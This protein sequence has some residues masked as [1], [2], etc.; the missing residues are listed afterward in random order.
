MIVVAVFASVGTYL[1][2]KGVSGLV[3]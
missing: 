2:V 3:S 1:V